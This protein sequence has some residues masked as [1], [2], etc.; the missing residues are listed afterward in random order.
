M[1]D[2]CSGSR[3]NCFIRRNWRRR[4]RRS[5]T[6]YRRDGGCLPIPPVPASICGGRVEE[7]KQSG[8]TVACLLAILD[9]G[10]PYYDAQMTQKVAGLGI[11][12]FACSLEMLSQT[13]G[14][15]LRHQDL[16]T[17]QKEFRKRRRS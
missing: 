15:V 10:R 5:G 4:W 9:A 7:M 11:P 17:F 2:R 14:R 6:A 1:T 16:T 3:R 8:V 12:C 13:M